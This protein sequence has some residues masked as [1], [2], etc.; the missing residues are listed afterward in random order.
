MRKSIITLFAALTV[1]GVAVPASADEVSP[2]VETVSVTVNY[3][4][5]DLQA[6]EGTAILDK[7]IEAAASDVCA[8]P[9]IR[10]L[11]AMAAWEA[12]K[13]DAKAGALEQL[14]ILS[15]YENLALASLF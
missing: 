4:D 6:P 10:D 5:L 12:C 7:R 13:A 11:K 14:S 1:S 9:D 15:P 3:G 8:K 2:V